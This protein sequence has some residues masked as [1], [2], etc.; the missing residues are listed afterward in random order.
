MPHGLLA[1]RADARTDPLTAGEECFAYAGRQD[2]MTITGELAVAIR[3]CDR[4]APGLA[5]A[6]ARYVAGARE[7]GVAI[8]RV[9]ALLDALVFR[10]ARGSPAAPA[11]SADSLAAYVRRRALAE[12]GRAGE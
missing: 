10:H 8:T 5:A 4:D 1:S 7:Q 3:P 2:A 11:E 6:I 9:L 12:Y